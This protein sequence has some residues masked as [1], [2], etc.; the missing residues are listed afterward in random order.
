MATYKVI[1]GCPVPEQLYPILSQIKRE[2]GCSYNSIYRGT[3][4][5]ALLN[6]YGK[7]DQAWLYANSPP[8]VANPPGRSTHELRSDGVAYSG[9]VGRKLDWWQC[10]IDINDSQV[11]QFMAQAKRHGWITFRP[12]SSGVEYH[13][14]NFTKAPKYVNPNL[15]VG[16]RGGR[17]WMVTHRLCIALSPHTKKR[18]LDHRGLYFSKNLGNIVKQ[19]QKDYHLTPDGVVGPSTSAT[20]ASAA[21]YSKKYHKPM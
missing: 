1:D 8:G 19:F 21:R 17:V 12:Y 2:I 3:D 5:R 20:L 11:N 14:V 13:H 7:H 9:P 6:Q 18:Y 10:G 4:A 16:S 15:Q